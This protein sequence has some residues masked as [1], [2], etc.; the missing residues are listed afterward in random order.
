MFRRPTIADIYVKEVR[1]G[2]GESLVPIYSPSAAD[3]R[4][5]TIGRFSQG[6]FEQRGHL[7]EVPAARDWAS[8]VPLAPPTSPASF[9]FVSDGSVTIA[10]SGTVNVAGQNLL[11]ARLS[12][13]GNRAVVASF[14]G[15]VESTV[16]SPRR[17]DDLLWKL[18]IEGDL[19]P[20]EVVAWVV[21][22]AASGTVLVNRKGGV[23]IELSVDPSLVAGVISFQG[24]AVGVQFG[25]GSSAS[26][27]TSGADLAVAAKVKGLNRAGDEVETRRGFTALDGADLDD[28]L[29][30]E[31]PEVTADSVLAGADFSQDEDESDS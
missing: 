11:S 9:V 23:D 29:G 5:G 7:D 15:V 20:D 31:V 26:F 28:Y 2:L 6:Q 24:L 25:A 16:L 3:V 21:R 22:R 14:S 4:V 17:F 8:L 10:P 1:T 13:T 12:F 27:Q 19:K 30:S 18:Y